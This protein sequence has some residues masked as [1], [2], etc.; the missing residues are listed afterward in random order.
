[1]GKDAT[2]PLRVSTQNPRYFCHADGDPVYLTGAHT[3][4][5]LQDMGK[6]DPPPPFDW[7]GYLDFLETHG[8]N[9]IRLWRWSLTTW[10]YDGELIY[11]QPFPWARTGPGMALDGKPRFDLMQFDEAYFDRLRHRVASAGERGI[12]V[13]VMCFEGH[14]L[15]ASQSPWCWDGHP[16]NAYNN[17][18][19]IDGDLRGTGRGLSLHTLADSAV[20]SLQKAYVRQVVETVNDLDN[21]LFEITNESGDWSTSWQYAMIDYIHE[22]E[23]KLPKQHP[24]GMTFQYGKGNP[25]SNANLFASPAEWIS[26][27]PEG[28]YKDGPPAADGRKVILSDTDHLWGIGGNRAWVWQTCCQGMNPLFMDPY[29]EPVDPN[30]PPYPESQWTDHL[31]AKSA[32]DQR[33]ADIRRNLGYARRYADRLPLRSAVPHGELCATGY[34]LAAPGQAYLVYSPQP[35]AFTVDLRAAEGLLQLEWFDPGQGQVVA[36]EVVQGGAVVTLASPIARDAVA[37]LKI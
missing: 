35:G 9:F 22:L 6:T 21:V 10:T 18:N 17:V 29:R 26:P 13:S 33:W 14:G 32:L 11:T 25:G 5:N 1:M 28:G 19:G 36:Q 31:T 7:D 24:V 37:L 34:C 4:S 15:H 23:A 16:F 27:N 12:Y 20:T 2:G 3:W 30:A 8:H